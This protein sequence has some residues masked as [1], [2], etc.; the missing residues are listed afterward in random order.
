MK[1]RNTKYE[2]RSSNVQ[3]VLNK[4]PKGILF[5]GNTII[6]LVLLTSYILCT[7]FK[8]SN[9][10]EAPVKIEYFDKFSRITVLSNNK[11]LFK[12]LTRSSFKGVKLMYGKNNTLKQL[13]ITTYIPGMEKGEF[14]LPYTITFTDQHNPEFTTMEVVT[15]S[16]PF[17]KRFT[18]GFHF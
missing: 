3:D 16:I 5:W 12:S 1:K 10:V 17:S 15:D 13:S 8:V 6:L 7:Q 14:L 18:A 11:D 2:L 9:F 4:P